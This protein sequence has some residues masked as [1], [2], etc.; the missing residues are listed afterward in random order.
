[1]EIA[2]T[3][4]A[5]RLVATQPPARRLMM[6]G[7]RKARPMTTIQ[8][9]KDCLARNPHNFHD[10]R[11]GGAMSLHDATRARFEREGMVEPLRKPCPYN[12]GTMAADAWHD[13]RQYKIGLL[14]FGQGMPRPDANIPAAA[15][16]DWQRA[17]YLRQW[18]LSMQRIDPATLSRADAIALRADAARQNELAR[19]AAGMARGKRK[20]ELQAIASAH[21]RNAIA[22][23]D[24]IDGPPDGD[25]MSD[26]ELL[27][28]L[29]SD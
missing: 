10:A 4:R 3:R 9:R 1:M 5:L 14:L 18:E 15:G 2:E 24:A 13:G 20:R 22:L 17:D 21:H 19:I 11:F 12:P 6:A 25:A 8:E 16:Y 28:A 29:L 7:L 26:T 23:S 27:A